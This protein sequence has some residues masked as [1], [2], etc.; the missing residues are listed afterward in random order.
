MDEIWKPSA[1]AGHALTPEMLENF[2]VITLRRM[3]EETVY[4]KPRVMLSDALKRA[5]VSEG[6]DPAEMFDLIEPV[7]WSELVENN[8]LDDAQI[9]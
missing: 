9:E 1:V 7:T 2:K 6:I 5:L 3:Q 4:R 8:P